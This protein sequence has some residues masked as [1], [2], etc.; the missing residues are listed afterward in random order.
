MAELSPDLSFAGIDRRDFIKLCT[1]A[2]ATMGLG[3]Q[4]AAQIQEAITSPGRPP[5]IWIGAQECTGCTTSLLRATHPTIENLIL[6][7]ISLEYHEVLNAGAGNLAEENKVEAMEKYKGKYVLVVD[8]T[9]P[10]P[11]NGAYCVVAGE[12]ITDHVEHAAKNAAAVIA[13][14]SCAAWGGVAAARSNPSGA[15]SVEEFFKLKGITT[16]LVNIPGCPPNPQNFLTTVLYLVT[17]GKLPELDAKNRPLFAYDRLIHEH[18]ERRP[19]F[20]AGRFAHEFGD[21]GHRHGWCLYRLGCK[22]PQT[23]GNCPSLEFCDLGGGVWPVG[24]GHPCFGCN[25]QGV[26]FNIPQ[27]DLAHVVNPTPRAQKP[28]VDN[29]EGGFMSPTATALVGGIVGLLVGVAVMTVKEI[30]RQQ[31]Q[32]QKQ[33]SRGG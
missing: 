15:I 2:A 19:H 13:I 27:F 3:S 31:G 8:G 9:I 18:C 14:G 25:E 21:E 10:L 23:Y 1:A 24:I 17:F 7:I 5:V 11:E 32:E 12:P 6:D 16:P 26:G 33:D 30:G 4:A 22:G 20:D 29:P 28:Y